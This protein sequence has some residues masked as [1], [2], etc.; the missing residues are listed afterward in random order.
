M[1]YGY[2]PVTV[3]GSKDYK[4]TNPG[5]F[6]TLRGKRHVAVRRTPANADMATENARASDIVF[7]RYEEPRVL[8]D[9][10]EVF[11]RSDPEM[12]RGY[13]DPR[14]F[15]DGKGISFTFVQNDGYRTWMVELSD[16][17]RVGP[18]MPVGPHVRP[19]KNGFLYEAADDGAVVANRIDGRKSV[20]FYRFRNRKEAL[21]ACRVDWHEDWWQERLVREV[22]VPE[23]LSGERG[24]FRHCGFNTIV[25]DR[26]ALLHFARADDLGKYYVTAMQPLDRS[27]IPIGAPEIIAEPARDIPHGDVPNVIYTTMAWMEGKHLIMWSGHDD[28]SIIECRCDLPNWAVPR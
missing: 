11:L 25:H 28:S 5:G 20:Q 13:E 7:L 4:Y 8:V 2:Q 27:G 6:V 21:A 24:S 16:G 19:A 23:W 17:E 3:I 9:T 18:L 12:G 26:L 1:A 22:S 10:D 15:P 14:V